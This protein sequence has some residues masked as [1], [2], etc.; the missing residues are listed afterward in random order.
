MA[1]H[2]RLQCATIRPQ[3][4]M[5]VT[6]TTVT[7]DSLSTGGVAGL[8]GTVGVEPQQMY[9]EHDDWGWAGWVSMWLM[10]ALFW[11]AVAAVVIWLVRSGRPAKPEGSTALDIA[12][13]RYAHGEISDE[14]FE[15]I[16]RGLS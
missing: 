8:T 5:E 7:F 9:G 10:I 16:K 12:R 11:V 4:E 6:M 2:A 3:L 13:T 1:N 15:R 14:E